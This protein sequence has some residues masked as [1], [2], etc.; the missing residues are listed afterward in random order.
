VG[1]VLAVLVVATITA[2]AVS[3]SNHGESSGPPASTRPRAPGATTPGSAKVT[4]FVDT[5]TPAA[6]GQPA[7]NFLL[8]TLDGTSI[9]LADL[10]GRPVIVNF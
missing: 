4:P 10:R 6:I 2:F 8:K 1:A 9:S 5:A 7:P 3:S